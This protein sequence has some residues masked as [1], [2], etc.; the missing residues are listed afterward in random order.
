MSRTLPSNITASYLKPGNS[1]R[2]FVSIP[3]A[4]IFLSTKAATLDSNAYQGHIKS[5]GTIEWSIDPFGGL[6]TVS[7]VTLNNLEIGRDFDL[8]TNASIAPQES[9]GRIGAGRMLYPGAFGESWESVRGATTAQFDTPS[10][11]VG[12]LNVTLPVVGTR[13]YNYRGI[14]QFA[15]PAGLTTCEQ[16]AILLEGL[17]DNAT[18]R[19]FDL[20]VVRGAWSS[21]ATSG[22]YDDFDGWDSGL[23]AYYGTVLNETWTSH[24]MNITDGVQSNTILLNAEG[25][26]LI[27]DNAGGTVKFMLLS[28]DDYDGE[29]GVG[30]PTGQEYLSF[31]SSN[32]TLE[33]KYNSYVLDNRE[34][35]VYL[36]Y[37]TIPTA[38]ADM[39]ELWTGVVDNWSIDDRTLSLELRQNN[40]VKKAAIPSRLISL[41]D[42]PY[43][44]EGNVGQAMPVVFGDFTTSTG[45]LR[46]ENGIGYFL[47]GVTHPFGAYQ[48]GYT[49]NF[50]KAISVDNRIEEPIRVLLSGHP[51]KNSD[52]PF[53]F[54][55]TQTERY[56]VYP[57]EPVT[58]TPIDEEVSRT[59][60]TETY[61]LI[62]FLP[63]TAF[64]PL[65]CIV[66]TRNE[67]LNS[68]TN[69]ERAYNR[70]P[71]DYA[72]LNT[73]NDTIYFYW[74]YK[75]ISLNRYLAVIAFV[76]YTGGAADPSL[77]A[78]WQY[79]SD[80]D[81]TWKNWGTAGFSANLSAGQIRWTINAI[82][83]EISTS[84]NISLLSQVRLYITRNVAGTGTCRLSNVALVIAGDQ[85]DNRYDSL[86][87][88]GQG[89]MYGSW[90]DAAGR[91][92]SYNEND[93]IESPVGICEYVA[94][95]YMGLATADIDTT[96]FDAAY[97]ELSNWEHAFEILDR[98]NT[99]SVID[100]IAIQ[101]RARLYW[102]NENKL[103]MIV[104]DESA[105][106][107]NAGANTPDVPAGLDI[108]DEN[109]GTTGGSFVSNPMYP[110]SFTI[111]RMGLDE[112]YNDFVLHYRKN[113]AS[114]DYEGLL[115]ITN[116]A[117]VSESVETNIQAGYLEN[118][119][120]LT[121]RETSLDKL[122]AQSYN[123]IQTTNTWEFDADCI[124]DEATATKLL[125]YYIER[126]T[127]RRMIVRFTTAM[128]ALGVELGDFINIRHHRLVDLIG[129]PA[130]NYK[131]WEVIGIR[132]NLDDFKIDI[133]AIE[134]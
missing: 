99:D 25:R 4:N 100:R 60:G 57:V 129:T 46:H 37:E 86:M 92:A 82:P 19:D 78:V 50:L 49:N 107:P 96:A 72:E 20:Y 10:V 63:E 17:S 11:M 68:P 90:I 65:R 32:L 125:Q 54:W 36:A 103:S 70:S 106:F 110:E 18:T 61:P 95:N 132:Y 88:Q 120:T 80:D 66:P 76:A 64:A 22:M 55:D 89:A 27:V 79:Y 62:N 43:C 75:D 67:V 114:G 83:Y 93:L 116:G 113:Y 84:V 30:A 108:F 48:Y 41:S 98:D 7:G 115:Y 74:N 118:G 1:P 97:T 101:A 69:P 38:T 127:K 45:S 5:A 105:A 104:F 12:R 29:D 56:Q 124:R 26:K 8:S 23:A 133:R 73:L 15:V 42:Y 58:D 130:M 77:Q 87:T 134:V 34:A 119:Q 121:G 109:A 51:M 111:D 13:Y 14:I 112:V 123:A 21:Y 117:G 9:A 2:V 35:T 6:G 24:M 3:S 28:K 102:T 71:I 31:K 122:C 39:L 126:L 91:T 81:S 40:Y 53:Y 16:A 128:T 33:L 59:L 44:P 47:G 94:R 131:R 52:K 85:G